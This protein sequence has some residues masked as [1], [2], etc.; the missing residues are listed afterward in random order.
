MPIIS[1]NLYFQNNLS[2]YSEEKRCEICYFDANEIVRYKCPK[3]FF[4]HVESHLKFKKDQMPQL[5]ANT[6]SFNDEILNMDIENS[7]ENDSWNKERMYFFLA[8]VIIQQ[9]VLSY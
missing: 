7:T 6:E 9:Y 1:I 4:R 8:I 5:P 2:T 3:N